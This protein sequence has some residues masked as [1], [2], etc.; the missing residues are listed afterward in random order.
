MDIQ[1]CPRPTDYELRYDLASA[2]AA[3]ERESSNEAARIFVDLVLSGD[4]DA[5]EV[6]SLR[7]LAANRAGVG[8]HALERKL[9]EPR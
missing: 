1:L 3:L 9:K 7:D 6:E 4:V 2:K 8:K 5:D